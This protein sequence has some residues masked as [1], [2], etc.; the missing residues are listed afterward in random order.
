MGKECIYD[1]CWHGRCNKK[2]VNGSDF[3]KEHSKVKC[4]HP[5][6]E[7]QAVGD[8]HGYAG[9]FVCGAPT[10]KEHKHTHI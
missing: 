9:S 2:T 10:C 8:C 6:C 7:E 4:S 5:S 3:C 1:I